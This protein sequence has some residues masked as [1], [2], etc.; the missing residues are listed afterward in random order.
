MSD[1]NLKDT[2]YR[3]LDSQYIMSLAFINGE[4]PGST[5]L[6]YHIDQELN[7]YFATHSDSYKA[8]SLRENPKVSLSVWEH[9]NMLVQEDGFAEEITDIDEKLSYVDKLAKSSTK[10]DD[11][12]P[13]LLRISGHEYA[14]FRIKPLWIRKLDL[15]VDTMTQTNTPFEEINF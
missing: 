14:V 15:T 3:F 4:K 12:W 11:F 1:Q 6:L 13:P 7:I 10:G 9:N 2:I 8:R 5:I